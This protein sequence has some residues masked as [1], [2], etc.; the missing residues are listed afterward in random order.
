MVPGSDRG[1]RQMRNG[2]SILVGKSEGK[3]PLGRCMCRYTDNIKMDVRDVTCGGVDRNRIGQDSVL[4]L[5]CDNGDEH[6]GFI[7]GGQFFDY[8]RDC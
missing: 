7:K 3:M 8:L 1:K 2:C 4:W 5:S 6:S